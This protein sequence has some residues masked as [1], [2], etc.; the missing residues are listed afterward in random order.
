ME[1]AV[2]Q[3]PAEGS[4]AGR[5]QG[6]PKALVGKAH[7]R[8]GFF[9]AE[10]VLGDILWFSPDGTLAYYNDTETYRVDRFDYDADTGLTGASGAL[11]VW[12]Q[13]MSRLD[14]QPRH[15]TPPSGI[16]WDQVSQ[17]AVRDAAAR[18]C[19][20]PR[21]LPFRADQAPHEAVN[22]DVSSSVLE[23]LMNR[24]RNRKP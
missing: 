19:T 7:A 15:S 4:R 24:L 23:R 16:E 12:T 3:V 14:I 18:D 5:E 21:L 10:G 13:I 17:T 1:A 2:T 8:P 6:G 22:C 20:Q 9:L 11:H